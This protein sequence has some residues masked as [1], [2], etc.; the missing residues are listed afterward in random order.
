MMDTHAL[1]VLE[2][3][4]RYTPEGESPLAGRPGGRVEFDHVGA[5]EVI[6]ENG[7]DAA[8]LTEYVAPRFRG[9]V[10]HTRD[11][12]VPFRPPSPSGSWV[13]ALFSLVA[14]WHRSSATPPAETVEGVLQLLGDRTVAIP[15]ARE[16]P[17]VS[18][19]DPPP[20]G[21]DRAT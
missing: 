17:A 5:V 20:G 9:E 12:A 10:T 11:W 8:A 14:E 21:C 4:G 6:V 19:A 13:E 16:H 2:R 1:P 18:I 7:Y 15:V 3:G